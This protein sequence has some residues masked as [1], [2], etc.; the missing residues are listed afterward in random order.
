M[1]HFS[2]SFYTVL[3]QLLYLLL[4]PSFF[5]VFVLV[6]EPFG[7]E[8]FLDMGR[9]LYSFNLAILLAIQVLC[10]LG[11]RA[12]YI[13]VGR[14]WAPTLPRY[15]VWCFVEWVLMAAFSALYLTLM[16]GGGETTYFAMLL[17]SFKMLAL[18]LIY[19]Y[20]FLTLS[21]VLWERLV[22]RDAAPDDESLARF[23]DVDGRLKLVVAGAAVRCVEAEENYIRIFYEDGTGLKEYQIRCSMKKLESLALRHGYVRCHRSYYVNPAHVTVLGRKPDG[24]IY[25]QLRGM[26][27]TIPVSARYYETLNHLL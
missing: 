8:G 14:R 27:R 15:I 6:Y 19:P 12:L 24:Q 4:V 25:A 26:S 9:G 20:G 10:L 7:L 13:C 16:R 21:R 2:A 23:Y 11:L 5:L 17:Q 3:G 1:K 18:V 22:E